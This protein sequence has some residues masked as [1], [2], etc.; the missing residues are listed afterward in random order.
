[1]HGPFGTGL[2][3][4]VEAGLFNMRVITDS[5]L[6]SSNDSTMGRHLTYSLN[7]NVSM[8]VY[9]YI[10]IRIYIYIY[11]CTAAVSYEILI[12]AAVSKSLFNE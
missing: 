10:Y 7:Y 8:Y 9:I 12:L 4:N 2:L 5:L 6:E 1:M 3:L 11:I